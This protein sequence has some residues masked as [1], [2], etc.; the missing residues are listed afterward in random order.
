[1][2]VRNFVG[3]VA[4][5]PTERKGD[6][7]PGGELAAFRQAYVGVKR[8]YTFPYYNMAVVRVTPLNVR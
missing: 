1:M 3:F 6:D 5:F 7:P 8:G 4:D 2:A